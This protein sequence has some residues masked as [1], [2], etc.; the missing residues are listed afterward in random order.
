MSNSISSESSQAIGEALP[1]RP[2]ADRPGLP[3]NMHRWQP[4]DIVFKR[5]TDLDIAN[6]LLVVQTNIVAP[7][8]QLGIVFFCP[9]Y[10]R[11]DVVTGQAINPNQARFLPIAELYH[12]S[13]FNLKLMDASFDK[14]LD[15]KEKNKPLLANAETPAVSDG[16][17]S[18]R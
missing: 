5:G 11:I 16:N 9:Y 14:Y 1:Q 17:L 7:P 8:G 18:D 13:E 15:W 4:G 2:I 3:V 12:Y 10:Q 6:A